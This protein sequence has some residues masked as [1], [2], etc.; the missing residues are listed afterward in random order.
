MLIAVTGSN[1]FVG[2]HLC[3]Y[4]YNQGHHV[5]FIQRVASPGC[6][7][8]PSIDSQTDWS[9]ILQ[10][11]DVV[12]HCASRVHIMNDKITD[13][14]KAYREVNVAGTQRLALSASALGVKRLVFLS[15]IKVN[16][17]CTK[18]GFPF[19]NKSLPAPDDPYSVSKF[20]AELALTSVSQQTGLEV[21]IVRPPLVYGPHVRA[22]FLRLLHLVGS[23]IPLPLGAVWNQRS[24]IYVGNL[25]SFLSICA[26]HSD[27]AGRRFL[28]SDGE[29]ISTAKL[30][31]IIASEMHCK[32][33]LIS[34]PPFLLKF[35][36]RL[37]GRY[38][39]LSRLT[40]S[41]VVE[42]NDS[43]QLLSWRPP[44]PTVE[45]IRV[46]V[47]WFLNCQNFYN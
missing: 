46:T 47:K 33:P 11:V 36:A 40:D 14:L 45:G 8:I 24:I 6:F 2:S 43:F 29:P 19:T 20:E 42:S 38:S 44:F 13:P 3:N 26:L 1:G 18:P 31:Q 25:V 9:N 4:L 15:S 10:G 34:V 12:I 5:R 39:Q 28:I 27:A 37:L 22:N 32:S 35:I 21:V 16:G 30:I 7:Q 17:E 23:K 41:L